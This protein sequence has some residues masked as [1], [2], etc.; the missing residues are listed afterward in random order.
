MQAR[1]AA[2]VPAYNEEKTIANV[3]RPLVGSG[4]FF[5]VIVVSDGSA[6]KTAE[7]AK[8]AGAV[9]YEL[10]RNRGKGQALQH[11]VTMTD[12]EIL[13]FCDADLYGFKKENIE[14][15]LAPVLSGAAAMSVGIRD[16]GRFLSWISMHTPLIGGE[17]AMIRGV[18]EHIPDVLVK[19]FMVEMALNMHCRRHGLKVA[20]IMM[21]G[22]TIRKKMQK[23]G[24]WIGLLQ[25]IKMFWQVGKAAVVVRL[26]WRKKHF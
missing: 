11:G 5:D 20:R 18:F 19:G 9:V 1:I 25:Y 12:A 15:V 17:R 2:I 3:V 16:R 10:P 7:E 14:A 23:V 24:F 4:L 22:V 8:R 13:F 21:P 26:G 6:D